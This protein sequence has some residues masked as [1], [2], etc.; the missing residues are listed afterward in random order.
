MQITLPIKELQAVALFAADQDV[1]YYLNSVA[2]IDNKLTATDGCKLIQIELNDSIIND[3][4]ELI[5]P[6]DMIKVFLKGISGADKKRGECTICYDGHHSLRHIN[7]EVL[8]IPIDAQYPNIQHIMPT[9]L[10]KTDNISFNWDYVA[11]F[12]KASKILGNKIGVAPMKLY[13]GGA[14]IISI[15][16]E[17]LV[18]GVV[19]NLRP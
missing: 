3:K 7:F 5:I 6:I 10:A 17:R 11:L 13:S 12:G 19:M 8:Y 2:I 9:K 18:T 4:R 15:S 16:Y 14:A 1:R